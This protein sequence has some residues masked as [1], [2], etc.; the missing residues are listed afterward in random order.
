MRIKSLP[1]ILLASC[2]TI[3]WAQTTDSTSTSDIPEVTINSQSLFKGKKINEQAS[4]HIYITKKELDIFNYTDPMRVIAGKPGIHIVEEDG[5]GLRPNIIIRGAASERSSAINLM[6]D[7]ILISPAP[8][9]AP[10]AYYFPNIGRMQGV[11]ILKGSGQVHQ[12]PNTVGG[13]FNM[14]STQV[15]KA[16]AI[17]LNASYGSFDTYKVHA[18]VGDRIGKF[19]YVVE[20]FTN[21]SNGFKDLPNGQ[22]TGFN[23][24][25]GVVKLLYDNS[26][27]SI[28]N[29]LQLKFQISGETSNETYMGLTREDFSQN[30]NQRYL[31]SELDQMKNTHK[32][33]IISYEIQPVENLTLNFDLYRNDF[34]RNWYKVNDI[35]AGGNKKGLTAVLNQA[36]NSD[37]ILA[38]KGLYTDDNTIFLR[39]NNRDYYSQGAQLNANY[40]IGINGILRFGSRFHQDSQDRFQADDLYRS[41]IYGLSLKS[42]GKPGTQDN[43]VETADAFAS[44]VQYQHDFGK[45]VA[46]LGLRYENIN[47]EQKNYGRNDPDRNQNV[48]FKLTE[49]NLDV[50]IPG[51]SIL[52]KAT[53]EFNMY[54]GVHKGFSPPGIKD[55]QKEES[56]INYELGARYNNDYLDAEIVGYVNDYSNM[57]GSDSN[58]VGGNNGTGDLFNVGKVTVQGIEAQGRYIIQGKSSPVNFPVGFSYTYFNSKFKEDY[59]SETYGAVIKG[60]QLPLIP[61]HQLNI[62]AGAN[63]N[64]F[65]FHA[66]YRYRGDFRNAPGQGDIPETDLVPSVGIFDINASY[67]ISRNFSIYI[68]GQ[69]IFNKTYLASLNPAGLRPGMPRFVNVGVHFKL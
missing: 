3:A 51:I 68:T 56:S 61:T 4:S 63:I 58:A 30:A 36:N 33:Y 7:G 55:G 17:N 37:E 27:A 14:V 49:N 44:Y 25:D 52:Y 42:K 19:G 64:K 29:K 40:K 16:R 13:T 65:S 22:N 5:F 66:I 10:A 31:A 20:Y 18:N 1:I 54:A 69:N 32:Q 23:I 11:E 39:N 46:T 34:S 38:L 53:N 6:E 35:Q 45:F 24:N 12:G 48:D 9:V 50:W 59:T 47:F 2:S 41:N 57:L 62:D 8:Y 28:P 26:D 67:G 15:P 60:D 43:R 21:N